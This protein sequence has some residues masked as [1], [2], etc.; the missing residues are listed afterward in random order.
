MS[1][2]SKSEKRV[3]YLCEFFFGLGLIEMVAGGWYRNWVAFAAGV[4]FWIFTAIFIVLIAV[5]SSAREA[6]E[7]AEAIAE[8]EDK[9]VAAFIDA[10]TGQVREISETLKR[11]DTQS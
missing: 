10:M 2:Y 11:K 7:K 9:E 1:E 3:I 8:A 4:T 6:K 5:S